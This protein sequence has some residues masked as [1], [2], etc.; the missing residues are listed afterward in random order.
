MWTTYEVGGGVGTERDPFHEH[1]QYGHPILHGLWRGADAERAAT[2]L[3]QYAPEA[4]GHI[5]AHYV[6]Y[7]GPNSNTFGDRCCGR[8][9]LHAS[10]AGDLGR[11]GLARHRRA[12]A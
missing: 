11:Q 1:G 4:A 7:P 3:A 2:C 6:F 9:G 5:E 12:P 10:L 8:C